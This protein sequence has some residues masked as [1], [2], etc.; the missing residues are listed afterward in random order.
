MRLSFADNVMF[1]VCATPPLSPVI[2]NRAGDV[3][4]NYVHNMNEVVER[5]KGLLFLFLSFLYFF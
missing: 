3:K 5:E 1:A 2:V 4:P